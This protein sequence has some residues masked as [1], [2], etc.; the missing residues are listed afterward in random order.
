VGRIGLILLLCCVVFDAALVS[1]VPDREAE[2][3]VIRDRI[4]VLQSRLNRVSR[5]EQ[6]LRGEVE[7]TSLAVEL[8]RERVEEARTA[9]LLAEESLVEVGEEVAELEASLEEIRARLK[10]SLADLYRLGQQGYMRMFLAIRSTGD[11]LPGIRQ[12]RFFVRRDSDLRDAYL[13]TRT[14]LAFQQE[15]MKQ[16]KAAVDDW[17]LEQSSRLEELDRL[18]RQQ[19]TLLTQLERERQSLSVQ[20]AE[21]SEKE[22]KLSNFLDFLYGRAAT[23]LSGTPVQNFKGVLDWPIKAR[24]E[25][26]FGPRLDPVYGTKVPHNGLDLATERGG[27][28]RAVFPGQVLFAAPFQGYGL[29]A[30]VHHP[31]RVFSLYAGLAELRVG[32]EDVLSLGQVIGVATDT[33]YFEIREENRPVDPAQW[34]R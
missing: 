29:T 24:V 9:R 25:K 27:E 28:V 5:E 3:E 23:P 10:Q 33:L 7:Q 12:M 30:V 17:L 8:Q 11:L 4:M 6:G 16:H 22:R 20:T 15:Q 26:G 34:L 21:L 13:E 1:Q 2:L 31:G 19:T 18:Q 32:A 14:A